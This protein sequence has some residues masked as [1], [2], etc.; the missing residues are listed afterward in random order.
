MV[1]WRK[2]QKNYFKLLMLLY[3]NLSHIFNMTEEILI[4]SANHRGRVQDWTF[5]VAFPT[6]ELLMATCYENGFNK[7]RTNVTATSRKTYFTCKT[8]G[9]PI[10][11]RAV[12]LLCEIAVKNE[13]F[14]HHCPQ[15]F[16]AA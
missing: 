12:T 3:H 14:L 4:P 16:R 6:M 1:M 2:I 5:L 8:S 13:N 10:S 7:R 11:L 15:A 9:C